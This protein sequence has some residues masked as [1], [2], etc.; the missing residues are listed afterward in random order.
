MCYKGTS[1]TARA[2]HASTLRYRAPSVAAIPPPFVLSESPRFAKFLQPLV[3]REALRHGGN[4]WEQGVSHSDRHR[5]G[6]PTALRHR[7]SCS[8]NFSGGT[9]VDAALWRRFGEL[10]FILSL[11]VSKNSSDSSVSRRAMLNDT[12][13]S[14]RTSSAMLLSQ[15]AV[16]L[17]RV[18]SR[19][20]NCGWATCCG[21]VDAVI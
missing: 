2:T 21:G 16:C 5:R 6:L 9:N 11:P 14:T 3:S 20:A 12:Q 8:G 1:A 13:H 4:R 7:I 15:I 10:V 18:T 17:A 19:R